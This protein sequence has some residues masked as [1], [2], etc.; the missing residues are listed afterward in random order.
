MSQ[1]ILIHSIKGTS[2]TIGA[3]NL[4]Q[5][6]KNLETATDGGD[7]DEIRLYHDELLKELTIVSEGIL[8]CFNKSTNEEFGLQ[9]KDDEII[10]FDP[11]GGDRW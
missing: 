4:A 8:K 1:R 9:M 5:K 6:A 10:E 3:I 11:K 7:I 2:K